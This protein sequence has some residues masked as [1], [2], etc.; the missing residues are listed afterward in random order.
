VQLPRVDYILTAWHLP[1]LCGQKR[2]MPS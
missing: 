2:G 1:D